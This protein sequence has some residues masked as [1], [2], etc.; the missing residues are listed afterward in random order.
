MSVTDT[1]TE[2]DLAEGSPAAPTAKP[3]RHRSNL[4][5]ALIIAAGLVAGGFFM[6]S[7]GSGDP[8]APAEEPEEE[9]VPGEMVTLEPMTLNLAD[10]RY[11]RL[12]L[13]VELVEGVPGKEWV[14]HGGSSRYMDL[15]IDRVG[16]WSGEQL[17]AEDGRGELKELLR[18]GGSELFEEEFS[19]VYLTEYIV[20]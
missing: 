11:L 16:G 10:G 3:K 6:G 13:A 1:T 15:I 12:G 5:P 17:T 4:V 7:G 19:E 18:S 9:V 14:E 8:E 2:E 20:Q